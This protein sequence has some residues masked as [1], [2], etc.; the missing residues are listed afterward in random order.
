MREMRYRVVDAY[1]KGLVVKLILRW[2][3]TAIS[4]VV[5]VLVIPGITLEGDNAFIAVAVT[6]AILGLMNAFL[7]PILAFLAC[8]C[9]VITLGFALLFINAFVLWASSWIAQ[10]WLG[11]QFVVDGFWPAFWGGIVISVVSFFL[12]MFL[13]DEEPPQSNEIVI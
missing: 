6:A 2:I 3:I 8:G 10:N 9:V 11:I 5:A 4:L 13:Y 1:M 12:S 7:R